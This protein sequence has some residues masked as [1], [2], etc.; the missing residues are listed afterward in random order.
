MTIPP[1]RAN[2]KESRAA[3]RKKVTGRAKIRIGGKMM[4][5]GKMMD[6]SMTGASVSCEEI[7]PTRKVLEI[8]VDIFHEGRKCYF[9]AQAIAVYHVLVGGKGYKIGLQFGPLSDAAKQ[10]L[11]NLLE[12]I[13]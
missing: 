7:I 8:E 2:S 3:I 1:D 13:S 12:T 5:Q 11:G 4:Y 10:S 9:V 6:I